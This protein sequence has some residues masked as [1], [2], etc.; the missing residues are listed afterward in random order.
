MMQLGKPVSYPLF[1]DL[2]CKTNCTCATVH[3]VLN[4]RV[5][6]AEVYFSDTEVRSIKHHENL[7]LTHVL[8]PIIK[9]KGNKAK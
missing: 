9:V 4:F 1:G 2:G 3:V 5:T 7:K 6:E 8:M